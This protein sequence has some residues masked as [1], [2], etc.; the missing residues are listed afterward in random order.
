MKNPTSMKLALRKASSGKIFFGYKS[1]IKDSSP[2]AKVY[3][4]A[5]ETTR[6]QTASINTTEMVNNETRFPF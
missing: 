1:G 5:F 3:V 2:K 6:K 4:F